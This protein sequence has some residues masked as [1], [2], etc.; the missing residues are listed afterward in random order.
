MSIAT[1]LSTIIPSTLKVSWVFRPLLAISLWIDG[2]VYSLVA[3]AYKLFLTMCR[4]N[5]NQLLTFAEPLMN[6]IQALIM[7]AIMFKIGISLIQYMLNPDKA[8][9]ATNGGIALIKR[10]LIVVALL[11][12]YNFIFGFL[13][14]LSLVIIGAGDSGSLTYLEPDSDNNGLVYRLV[15][16]QGEEGNTGVESFGDSLAVTT[17]QL[18]VLNSGN[19]EYDQFF[20]D[21]KDGK[22]ELTGMSTFSD[23]IGTTVAYRYPILSAAVGA[24]LIYCIVKVSI[25]VGVRMFKL[26]VLQLVAPVAIICYI[27]TKQQ[28]VTNNF[29]KAYFNTYVD[30]FVRIIVMFLATAFI[31]MASASIEG[32]FGQISGASN[33][34]YTKV[35]LLIIIIVAAYRFVLQL[36]ALISKVFGYDMSKEG[37]VS[38]SKAMKGVARGTGAVA[39]AVAGG[40]AGGL[41]GGGLR[42]VIGGIEAGAKGKTIS[43]KVKGV[44]ESNQKARDKVQEVRRMGG[45]LEYAKAKV[46]SKLGIPQRKEMKAQE[47]ADANKLLEAATTAR[48][49]SVKN[50]M[51]Q[52]NGTDMFAFGSDSNAFAEKYAENNASYISKK[53]NFD[54]L[55]A[56]GTASEAQITSASNA[57]R[58]TRTLLVDEGKSKWEAQATTSAANNETYTRTIDE[59]NKTKIGSKKPINANMNSNDFAVE[60]KNNNKEAAKITN[61]NASARANRLGNYGK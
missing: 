26:L 28:S 7:V 11:V 8:S 41:A 15:F 33:D 22:K 40:V 61:N 19:N 49:D 58:A 56:S 44:G 16:G 10:I 46:E 47:Y 5:M 21:V 18:F 54:S 55:I 53:A 52:E 35:L 13:D 48:A 2:I 59:Y 60:K 14:D 3:Y 43:D 36:P 9:D 6:R 12:S 34:W 32:M 20:A 23:D 25:Q 39:G 30:V 1:L 37:G 51:Y 29:V 38:F 42:G 57:L 31:G 4:F 17:V 50:V 45:N 24:Y 27:D